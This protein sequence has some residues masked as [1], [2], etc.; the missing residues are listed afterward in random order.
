MLLGGFVKLKLRL[1]DPHTRKVW[2]A[3]QRAKAEVAVWPAWK[4]GE[5]SVPVKNIAPLCR[6]PICKLR[7]SE[8]YRMD[9]LIKALTI[10]RKYGNPEYP[11][12]C[13][14]EVMYINIPH[15]EVSEEDLMRLEALGFDKENGGTGFRSYKY[16]SC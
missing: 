1:D 13:G 11:T 6:T 9:D 5:I 7:R 4:L 8:G 16:G 15:S 12:H 14:H 3:I 2:Q 10:L